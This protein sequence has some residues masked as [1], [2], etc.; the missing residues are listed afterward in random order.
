MR[1]GTFW[2]S[3]VV[4]GYT[5]WALVWGFMLGGGAPVLA[6]FAVWGAVWLA[7][8]RFARWAEGTRRLLWRRRGYY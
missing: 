4:A 7:F 5:V 6:F 1:S 3:V 2:R 8:S